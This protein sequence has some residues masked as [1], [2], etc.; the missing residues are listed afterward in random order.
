M[1]AAT[2]LRD[3][4]DRT[5]TVVVLTRTA[6]GEERSTPIWAVVV[7]AEPYIRSVDGAAG[8]WF[9]RATARGRVAFDVGSFRIEADVER[10]EDATTLADVDAA[11]ERKYARQSGSLASMLRESARE[12][13]LRLVAREG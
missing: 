11:L 4:L 12:C 6:A 7:A 1:S 8:F 5:D 2:A 10:V 9:R 3:H 13:T